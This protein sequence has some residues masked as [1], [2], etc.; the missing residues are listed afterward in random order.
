MN[1]TAENILTRRFPNTPDGAIECLR[2]LIHED[3]DFD[4]VMTWPDHWLHGVW[5]ISGLEFHGETGTAVV[6]MAGYNGRTA[7]D[8]ESDLH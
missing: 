2:S 1:A 5:M 8:F 3:V 7:N 4:H 6:Y